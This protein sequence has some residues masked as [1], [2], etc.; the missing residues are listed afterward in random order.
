MLLDTPSCSATRRRDYL[1]SNEQ[2]GVLVNFVTVVMVVSIK[3][4]HTRH[5]FVALTITSAAPTTAWL[6]GDIFGG[7]YRKIQ[8]LVR[9]KGSYGST[10]AQ[11]DPT[12]AKRLL[13]YAFILLVCQRTRGCTVRHRRSKIPLVLLR[14]CT[15]RISTVEKTNLTLCW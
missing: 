13:S 2:P 11:H 7:L 5:L 15:N 8:R 14:T 1:L 10:Q 4:K 3:M 9:H 6:G 12:R